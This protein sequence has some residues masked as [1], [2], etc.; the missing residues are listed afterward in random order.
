ME[1]ST[2]NKSES[3]REERAMARMLRLAGPR[4]PVPGDAG[5]RVYNVVH[6]VWKENAGAS[7]TARV[8]ENVHREWEKNGWRS[9]LRRWAMPLA[10]A[11]SVAVAV[12][13]VL[14]QQ[15]QPAAVV[16]P[17]G[18][19]AR[20]I[21]TDDG[22]PLPGAGSPVY[23]GDRL[24]TGPGEGI[25]LRLANGESLR[26]DEN[27]SMEILAADRFRLA[28]GRVYAD[29]GDLMYRQNRLVIDT[30]IATVTDIG[31]QFAVAAGDDR[32]DVAV[33]EGRVDVIRDTATHV[34]IAG[35]RIRLGPGAEAQVEE[36]AAH[37]PYWNWAS[38]LAPVFDIE[39][40]SL[41]DFLR[42]AAR[43]TG[44]DLEFEDQALRMSAM[45]TDLHGSVAGF[46]PLEAIESVLATTTYRY[47]IEADKIVISR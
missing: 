19:V 30:A 36:I 8:Y 32:L 28:R 33:R 24:A 7:R 27:S 43:E 18:T 15:P 10:L 40:K 3:E 39:N 11:A 2:G 6:Q 35:E 16:N 26:L 13:V 14:Q 17:A 44:R 41:L 45:R 23:P 5:V 12:A 4:D 47:R 25:S 37:D 38:D 42:W 34:T 21:D 31:T 22:R 20:S 9:R 29:T 1:E 46:A